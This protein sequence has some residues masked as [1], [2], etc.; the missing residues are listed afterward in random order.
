MSAELDAD[1]ARVR[2]GD[3]ADERE[4]LAEQGKAGI[5]LVFC[6]GGYPESM[7]YS[8]AAE[9]PNTVFVLLPG[10][11]RAANVAGVYFLSEEVGYLAGAVA[12]AIAPDGRIGLLR[13]SGQPWLE[14][15]EEGY[16]EGFKSR[17]RRTQVT[18]AEGPDGVWELSSAGVTMSLYAADISDPGVLAAAHDA[19]V[20]LVVTDPEL[21]DVASAS[22]VAAV[23]V[24]VAE[25]MLRVGRE[26]RDRT[27]SDRDFAFDLGSGVLDV[28][29]NPDLEADT[30]ATANQALED[31]RAEITAGLVEFDGLGL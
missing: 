14:P 19:G 15:L 12:G 2:V 5:N 30:L 10:R 6:V 4:L 3:P 13:G 25:A 7:L 27:F 24:D 11:A 22:V 16:V 17:W 18:A 31:A 1:V 9:Y 20:R 23:D 8:V 28:V 21:F 26:V 29:V